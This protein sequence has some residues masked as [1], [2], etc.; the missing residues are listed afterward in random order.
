MFAS[1]LLSAAAAFLFASSAI[2]SPITAVP[3]VA[4]I[5]AQL[6]NTS[7]KTIVVETNA[8]VVEIKSKIESFG[9][10]V[11]AA[12]LSPLLVEL[13]TVVSGAVGQIT[14]LKT[15]VENLNVKA[16]AGVGADL[17]VKEV[18]EAVATLVGSVTLLLEGLVCPCVVGTLA[19]EVEAL[20]QGVVAEVSALLFGIQ[21]IIPGILA[22]V[23]A[24]VSGTVGH[25][26]AALKIT[27]LVGVLSY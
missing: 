23:G 26:I 24:L 3:S 9:V 15:N 20:V 25:I 13:K 27:A 19:Y 16:V 6:P 11:T 7:V 14:T 4:I 8:K 18:S 1:T 2:C 5:N 10:G 12:E 22:F 21:F 17:S